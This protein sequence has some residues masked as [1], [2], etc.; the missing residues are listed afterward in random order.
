MNT[1]PPSHIKSPIV[2]FH[3]QLVHDS[4]VP[5][6]VPPLTLWHF[7]KIIH[8]E[9]F[10]LIGLGNAYPCASLNSW[11]VEFFSCLK[12]GGEVRLYMCL[13]DG[14]SAIHSQQVC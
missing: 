10:K 7:T 9:S 14:W 6:E 3:L 4:F 1:K 8:K 2:K 12:R 5:H 13:F 11:K